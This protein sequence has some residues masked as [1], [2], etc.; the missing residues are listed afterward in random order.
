[1]L[2]NKSRFITTR[3]FT[4]DVKREAQRN[5]A[6]PIDLIDGNLLAENLRLGVA[7][8]IREDVIIKASWFD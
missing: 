3:T 4:R 7:I 8:R 6:P 1:M 5:G 2:S